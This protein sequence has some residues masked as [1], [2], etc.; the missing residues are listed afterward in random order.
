[1]HEGEDL[2]II[3]VE[4][5]KIRGGNSCV[6]GGGGGEGR[7]TERSRRRGLSVRRPITVLRSNA[8]Q[9]SAR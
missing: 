5:G 7:D 1:M 8:A 9:L 4:G 3:A 2:A 6:R